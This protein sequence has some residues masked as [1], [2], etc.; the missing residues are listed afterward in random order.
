[1]NQLSIQKDIRITAEDLLQIPSGGVTYAGLVHNITVA[2]LFIYNWFKG[3]G[4]FFLCGAVEDSATAEISRS[5][6]WQ[7]IRHQ[8]CVIMVDIS[9]IQNIWY[10]A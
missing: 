9:H 5:Q 10:K 4:H 6:I 3:H 8:V 7:W 2:I 1:V